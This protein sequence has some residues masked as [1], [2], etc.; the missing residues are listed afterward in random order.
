VPYLGASHPKNSQKVHSLPFVAMNLNLAPIERLRSEI[1]RDRG[2]NLQGYAEAHLTLITP[3]EIARDFPPG[4]IE[5]LQ[6]AA[7]TRGIQDLTFRVLG[8]GRAAS[9]AR[10]TFFLVVESPAIR[11]FRER[12]FG[13]FSIARVT[14]AYRYDPHITVGFTDQDLHSQDGVQKGPENLWISW[15]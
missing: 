5:I 6:N 11:A 9:G 13:D 14:P 3:P 15:T 7:F 4:S 2:L 12:L 10:Q 8:L 1:S